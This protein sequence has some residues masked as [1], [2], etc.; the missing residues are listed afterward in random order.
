M[1]GVGQWLS[2]EINS[3]Y[4]NQ[5]PLL[6]IMTEC[7]TL[8]ARDQEEWEVKTYG[9]QQKIQEADGQRQE[10]RISNKYSL[11]RGKCVYAP[12]WKDALL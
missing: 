6:Q 7:Y 1:N 11:R 9:F 8:L 2:S 10:F 4:Q 12:R 5:V 3:K